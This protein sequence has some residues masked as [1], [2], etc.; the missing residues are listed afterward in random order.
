MP[1][2]EIY[3]VNLTIALPLRVFGSA[4]TMLLYQPFGKMMTIHGNKTYINYE[5]EQLKLYFEKNI[6]TL[7]Y[8]PKWQENIIRGR[9][10]MH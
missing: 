3:S 4:L 10:T 6:S 8:I 1:K 7:T 2:H 9:E 5:D